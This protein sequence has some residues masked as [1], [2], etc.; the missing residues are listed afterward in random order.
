MQS[1]EKRDTDGKACVRRDARWYDK[2]ERYGGSYTAVTNVYGQWFRERGLENYI[3]AL[4][5]D[6]HCFLLACLLAC[7]LVVMIAPRCEDCDWMA[8]GRKGGVMG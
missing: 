8:G 6:V 2:G 3:L 7:L 1:V 4:A 5:G